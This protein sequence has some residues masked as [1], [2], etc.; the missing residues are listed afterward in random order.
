MHA[1]GAE[2]AGRAGTPAWAWRS[3]ACTA[4]RPPAAYP[5][6]CAHG[7]Q[8]ADAATVGGVREECLR[9]VKCSRASLQSPSGERA[10]SL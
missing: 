9:K 7:R 1:Q 6:S 10:T 4:P 8:R 5:S 3:R 2:M